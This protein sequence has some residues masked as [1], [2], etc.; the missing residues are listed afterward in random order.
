M[1]AASPAHIHFAHL[2][3]PFRA[4]PDSEFAYV[5]PI[6]YASMRVAQDQ[7]GPHVQVDLLSAQFAA[8]RAAVPKGFVPTPDLERSV[9]DLVPGAAAPPFP[10]IRDLLDRLYDHSAAEYLIYTNV[11]IALQPHF[12]RE[13][14][15]L[16]RFG[17]RALI[18]NRRRIPGHYRRVEQL[19]EMYVERGKPHPGFDCFVFH[20]SIYPRF[21]LAQVCVGIPFIGILTAQNVFAFGENFRLLDDAHLTFHIGEDVFKRRNRELFAHNRR[22]FWRAIGALDP[23]LDT[24][25]WPYHDQILPRRLWRWGLHPSLPIRLALK[26]EWRQLIGGRKLGK[27]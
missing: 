13:V 7:A 11:D 14:A 3:N 16:L 19:P 25:K 17:H 21:Q 23:D 9:R 27:G 8:D 4:S 10:L 5:Q 22:E 20:R 24:R 26:L 12:Y 2:I 1:S 18:I 15:E 6:T